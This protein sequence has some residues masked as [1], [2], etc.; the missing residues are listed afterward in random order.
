MQKACH[1]QLRNAFRALLDSSAC[2]HTASVFDPMSARIAADLGFE[3]GILGGSVAS[4]QVLAAPDIA[5]IT[6]S[7]FTEQA[8]RIGRVARLPVIADADHGYGNAL[9]AMRTVIE[10]ERAGV[11]ALTLEDTLLPAQFGRKSY[12]L[13]SVEEG[14]GKLRAAQEVRDDKA[15][16]LI[17]RTHAGVQPLAEV[18]QRTQAYQAAGADAICLVGVQDCAHL[19]AIAEGLRVPLM[20]VTY[21]NPALRD[22]CRLAELGVRIA[23]DGHGAYFAAIKATYDSLRE[24]RGIATGN[25][26]SAS[27]LV[28]RYTHPD[29]YIAWAREYMNVSE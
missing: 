16:A 13:I 8:T 12:E 3:V 17:A 20:L 29:D 14:V 22:D 23:V 7:E 28:T 5:L 27:E 24:Q 26:L 19:E 21:G 4:L 10:L 2:Y 25:G 15:L 11:A 9:N 1:H 6:L 18:I